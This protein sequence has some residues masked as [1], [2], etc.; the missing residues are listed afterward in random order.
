LVPRSD[1]WDHIYSDVGGRIARARHAAGL[2]Q[3]Q[4]ADAVRVTRTSIV[5]IE[6]G[7]QRAPLHVLWQIAAATDVDVAAFIPTRAELAATRE[8]LQLDAAVVTLIEKAAADDAST[9]RLLMD[10]IQQAKATLT[11]P[12]RD[13]T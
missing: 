1:G 10:F 12:P 13:A 5:N 3:R 4:L 9:K 11:A 8:P 2:S 6:A 7:R